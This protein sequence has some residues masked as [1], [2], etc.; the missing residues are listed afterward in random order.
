MTYGYS[1][2]LNTDFYTEKLPNLHQIAAKRPTGGGIVFHQPGDLTYC[3]VADSRFFSKSIQTSCSD[4][5]QIISNMLADLNIV[6]TIA[7]QHTMPHLKN[8]FE[9]ICF[10]TPSRYELVTPSGHKIA[11]SAQRRGKHTLLQQGAIPLSS[12]YSF[13]APYLKNPEEISRIKNKSTDI[14]TLSGEKYE[15]LDLANKL[16]QRFKQIFG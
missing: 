14:S 10:A 5:H 16:I 1:Q 13:W 7:K 3:L 6:T 12:D 15:F 4:I 2:Q 8:P 11:G 9:K